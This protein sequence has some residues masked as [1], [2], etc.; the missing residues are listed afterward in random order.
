M[1]ITLYEFDFFCNYEEPRYK[2][3]DEG[4]NARNRHS[5][6][7]DK[8]HITY[9]NWIINYLLCWYLTPIK[10]DHDYFSYL[11]KK[12]KISWWNLK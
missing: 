12:K 2:L 9:V 4:A 11:E 1:Y 10:L 7:E 3:Q 6:V 8:P 5:V